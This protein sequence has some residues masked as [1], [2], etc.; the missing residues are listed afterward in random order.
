MSSQPSSSSLASSSATATAS[1]GFTTPREPRTIPI[2][3]FATSTSTGETPEEL[4]T[5]RSFV[6]FESASQWSPQKQKKK[7][8]TPIYSAQDL[9]FFAN[10]IGID[11]FKEDHLLFIARMGLKV[12]FLSFCSLPPVFRSSNF[13]FVLVLSFLDST[14]P[15]MEGL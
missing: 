11:P 12:V 4:A 7:K 14:Q 1:A 6:D 3:A 2:D 13:F 8:R 15:P 5:D 10:L 9:V